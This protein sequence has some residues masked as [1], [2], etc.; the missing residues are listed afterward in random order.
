MSEEIVTCPKCGGKA[1]KLPRGYIGSHNSP[2]NEDGYVARCGNRRQTLSGG[3]CRGQG[4]DVGRST[5][6]HWTNRGNCP[7]CG[8]DLKLSKTGRIPR[9]VPQESS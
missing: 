2:P 8:K 9:H 4:A 6:A 1:L 5:G 7:V 3:A